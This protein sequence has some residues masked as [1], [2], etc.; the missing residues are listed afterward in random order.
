MI[1]PY[2]YFLLKKSFGKNFS[3]LYK[4]FHHSASGSK[5]QPWLTVAEVC[6]PLLAAQ[7]TI[8]NEIVV[9]NPISGMLM[10]TSHKITVSINTLVVNFSSVIICSDSGSLPH[11]GKLCWWGSMYCTYSV[12]RVLQ[13]SVISKEHLSHTYI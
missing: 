11:P 10:F 12:H 5:I 13:S 8:S 7:W 1:N 9:S 2:L 3:Q 6:C 4:R